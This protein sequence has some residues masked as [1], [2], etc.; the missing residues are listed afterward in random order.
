MSSPDTP[1]ASPAELALAIMRG[2]R[3]AE[4]ALY[5]RYHP[6]TLFILERRIGDPELAQ[7]LCQEA[8]CI[9][10][11]RL[12]QQPLNEPDKL[13]AFLHST[14]LN[15]YIAETRKAERRKTFIDPAVLEELADGSQNQYRTLL[16][17]R[18]ADAVRRLLAALENSRDRTLLYQY[19]IQ[20]KDKA[21]VCADL[22]LT[23]RHFDRVLFRAKQR[24]K[25][26]LRHS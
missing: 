8:M 18:S 19:Y 13:A 25:E 10:L 7:D 11:E 5:A 12:R 6:Q 14:A 23:Q 3:N 17:Q 4:A 15:L 9:A 21:Q 1:Y 2:D 26:L 22:G 24:F 20:E 16:R